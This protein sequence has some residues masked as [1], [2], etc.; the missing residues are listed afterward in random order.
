MEFDYHTEKLIAQRNM[1]SLTRF[2]HVKRVKGAI[3]ALIAQH[4]RLPK[5][6][7]IHGAKEIKKVATIVLNRS[8]EQRRYRNA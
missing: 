1:D 5:E 6:S 8:E 3:S 7:R 2:M 4:N